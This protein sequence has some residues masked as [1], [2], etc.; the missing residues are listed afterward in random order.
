M[1]VYKT[2]QHTTSAHCENDIRIMDI[3]HRMGQQSALIDVVIHHVRLA[4]LLHITVLYRHIY[5]ERQTSVVAWAEIPLLIY[6]NDDRV[7][8]Y[9][10]RVCSMLLYL[11]ELLIA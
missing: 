4:M 6:V 9:R 11:L 3:T 10:M 7:L 5:M 8:Q 2:Q 1:C